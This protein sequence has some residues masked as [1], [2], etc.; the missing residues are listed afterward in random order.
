MNFGD[1][2]KKSFL[3]AISTG[4]ISWKWILFIT[5]ITC[6]FAAYIFFAYRIITRKTFYNKSFNISLA[7]IA[8][9]VAAIVISI[10]SSLVVSLG[11]VGALSIVRF[12]TAIKDPVD[13][14]FL[15]WSI[16]I[17]IICGANLPGIALI[18]SIILT[19]V[20]VVLNRIPVAKAPMILIVN[21]NE[22]GVREKI[23]EAVAT[24]T[25]YYT[26]KSQS[27]EGAQLNIV[28]ELR[29]KNSDGLIDN[30]SKIAGVTRCSL[31][32]HDGEVTF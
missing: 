29:T 10:Q 9:I 31:L 28:I 2:F 12:R 1:I 23:M 8:I 4:D 24:N 6:L 21:A 26:V 19:V 15:F 14:V 20:V 13:L 5:L 16:S 30:I 7:A 17:G 3:E 11:M 22:K 25:K 27:A 32:N 18:E